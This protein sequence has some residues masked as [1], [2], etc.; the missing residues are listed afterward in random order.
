MK[1]AV[2]N[3]KVY[4]EANQFEEALLMEDGVILVVG[5][6]EDIL[7]QSPDETIDAEGHTLIPGFN[8]S[9]SHLMMVSGNRQQVQ[10]LDSPSIEDVLERGRQF[11]KDHPDI[12]V[13]S[14]MGWNPAEFS[15]GELRNLTRHD[16]DKVSSDIPVLFTRACGHMIA[17]N[18]KAL[19]LAEVNRDTA[20]VPGG[21]FEVDDQG[22]P[23]GAFYE[24][25]QELVSHLQ[26]SMSKEDMFH[27][28][29]ETMQYALSLGIT[30]VQT[31][32]FGFIFP[33]PDA[34]EIYERLYA[35]DKPTLKTHH[36]MC[37]DS[38]E[39]LETFLGNEYKTELPSKMTWGP[40]KLFKDGTLGGRSAL[41]Y[42]AYENNPENHGVDVL[43]QDCTK[44]FIEVA[45]KHNLQ[46]YAHC[47]GERAMDEMLD[48]Y[49]PMKKEDRY[50][51]VHCQITRPPILERMKQEGAVAIIQPIFL[52]ADVKAM[53]GA[54]PEQT[55]L[56]SYA[57]K[58]MIDLGIPVAMGTDSPIEDLNPFANLYCAMER[59]DLKQKNERFN[60]KESLTIE[61]ALD[62]YTIGSAYAEFKED[63]KGRLKPGYQAD[64]VLLDRDIFTV[65]PEEVLNTKVLKTF[66]DGEIVYQA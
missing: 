27:A 11:L 47:I 39:E 46:V 4:V 13:L 30:T 64:M 8:D 44:P 57:W 58:T 2:I 41:M 61:E 43:P 62:A 9:H 63:K 32:D 29:Q 53:E 12:K 10:L 51:L 25:A 19:E 23:I 22:G 20:Q 14:G 38:A 7:K 66:V 3:A 49:Q 48:S 16:L 54:I 26:P 18:T 24:N 45:K 37:F 42:E 40:L 1:T 59:R 15:E 56:T 33:I 17:T 21:I 60:M 36:Q 31:N 52:R 50:A 28:M 5:S 35:S 65:S 6:S 55:Q 34:L